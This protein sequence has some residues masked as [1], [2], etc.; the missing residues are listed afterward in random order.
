MRF[1]KQFLG[2]TFLA[3]CA[4][5][6][7]HGVNN[8]IWWKLN[9]RPL[10]DD[11]AAHL[12]T[13]LQYLKVIS[14]HAFN[15]VSGI[16][17]VDNLYPP[18][19][20]CTAAVFGLIFGKSTIVFPMAN[21]LFLAGIFFC[22]YLI[23][24]K[25]GDFRLGVL[26]SCIL[27]LYPMFFH[28]SRM[29][30]LEIAVCFMVI[31]SITALIYSEG[32]KKR[33][34][35]TLFGVFLGLGLLTKQYTIV[36]II[37]PLLFVFIYSFFKEGNRLTKKILLNILLSFLMGISI[38]SLWYV[39]NFKQT[40]LRLNISAFAPSAVPEDIRVFSKRSAFYYLDML[41]NGQILLFFSLIFVAA[42]FIGFR[43]IKDKF[44]FLCLSWILFPYIVFT[45]FKNK[46]YYYTM[47]YLPAVA[48]ISAHGILNITHKI[49][50]RVMLSVILIVGFFQF[51][52][53]SYVDFSDREPF[54]NLNFYLD[55]GN[56]KQPTYFIKTKLMILPSIQ[57]LRGVRYHPLRG[58]YKIN[59]IILRI[60]QES[61]GKKVSLWLP[62]FVD[63][64]MLAK[65]NAPI[66]DNYFG[67]NSTCFMYNLISRSIPCEIK[68]LND[69][70]GT[71]YKDNTE[72]ILSPDIFE[73]INFYSIN[74]KEFL[75][76][77]TFVMPDGT[78]VYLYKRI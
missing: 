51:F 23:G 6:L 34:A 50:R 15:M 75:L 45:L 30:M 72:F 35:S 8:Y 40:F 36:F 21:I 14:Q 55:F 68:N 10:I 32:F 70:K 76:L 9:T 48:I 39:P 74:I 60:A 24:R 71:K 11:E 5:I 12:I 61:M 38:A 44:L 16:M 26:A 52:V 13:C 17:H 42:F 37:G 28:L 49:L 25:M 63:G 20:G 58:D 47:A 73:N 31:A 77:E 59:D 67:V 57:I 66:R 18:F 78:N 65:I 56:K 4:L 19:L 22:L 64:N 46:F 53:I 3:L 1:K 7:F 62:H 69:F 41:I 29:F 27:S 33:A 43:R 54:L 2:F